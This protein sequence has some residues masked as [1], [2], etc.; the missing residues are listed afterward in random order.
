MIVVSLFEKLLE[1]LHRPG[2]ESTGPALGLTYLRPSLL[3]GHVLK[4]VPLEQFL[5]FFREL[6]HGRP[7]PP[8]HLLQLD[9]LVSRQLIRHVIFGGLQAG[10]KDH[11]QPG[12]GRGDL[13]H[14]IIERDASAGAAIRQVRHVGVGALGGSGPLQ[15]AH[16][17]QTVVYGAFDSVVGKREEVCS[18]FWIEALGGFQKT[19][20]S[21]SHQLVQLELGVELLA[22]LGGERANVGPVFLENLWFGFRE[23]H[24]RLLLRLG[25]VPEAVEDLREPRIVFEL[26]ANLVRQML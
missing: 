22:N 6:I 26:L 24:G 20:L 3:Q 10:R 16:L 25:A 18:D 13:P 7:H 5:L 21:P 4:V 12:D 9:P 11:R 15:H 19:D 2:V 17:P 14:V 8:T 1:G 23:G